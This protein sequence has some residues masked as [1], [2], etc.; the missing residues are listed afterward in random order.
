MSSYIFDLEIL[1]PQ[2]QKMNKSFQEWF[3]TWQQTHDTY[4]LTDQTYEQVVKQIGEVADHAKLV[5]TEVADHIYEKGQDLTFT[6]TE[7]GV[8]V[9]GGV[10]LELPAEDN[11][12]Q[13]LTRVLKWIDK[14]PLV[15]FCAKIHPRS[16]MHE[17]L[18]GVDLN[19][20]CS[21]WVHLWEILQMEDSVQSIS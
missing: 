2:Y 19:H 4:I 16:K 6:A 18:H 15:L 11:K 1:T 14:R 17:I 12:P 10:S 8:D 20:V 3:I 9:G 5:F 13:D 21:N 7:T